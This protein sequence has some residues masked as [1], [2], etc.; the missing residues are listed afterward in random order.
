MKRI[1]RIGSLLLAL[2][3]AAPLG[4]VESVRVFTGRIAADAEQGGGT[5]SIEGAS[6]Y[7]R[8]GEAFAEAMHRLQAVCP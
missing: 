2:V 7:L 5:A 3:P 6:G 4:A 8:L 1:T